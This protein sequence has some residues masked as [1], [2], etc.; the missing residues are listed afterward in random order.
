MKNHYCFS[1]KI[2]LFILFFSA[3]LSNVAKEKKEGLCKKG[4][5]NVLFVSQLETISLLKAYLIKNKI[6]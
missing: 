3:N 4:A 2:I 5:L 1:F 6:K